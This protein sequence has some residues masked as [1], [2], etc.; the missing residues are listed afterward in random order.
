MKN[1]FLI[2]IAFS[3][4]FASCKEDPVEPQDLVLTEGVF[5]VNQGT[6]TAA[7]ASLSYIQPDKLINDLFY[8]VNQA[9]LGD[10]A[11]SITIDNQT[12]YIVV[13]NS[14][15]VYAIDRQTAEVRGKI[16][17]LVS[18]RHMLVI[19]DQKAYVSD[20]FDYNI[21]VVNQAPNSNR[22]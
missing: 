5:V 12:A 3:L 10:V 1:L 22:N 15:L 13:N 8:S 14:S 6:F 9:P 21:A 16:S 17:N 4:L 20:L 19:N 11:Q 18:P 2:L 7:N